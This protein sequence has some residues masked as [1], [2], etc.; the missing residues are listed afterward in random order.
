MGRDDVG[1]RGNKMNEGRKK[2]REERRKGRRGEREG[3]EKGRGGERRRKR[4]EGEGGG[5]CYTC[6]SATKFHIKFDTQTE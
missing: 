6:E 5:K 3:E 2:G 1:R 4:R